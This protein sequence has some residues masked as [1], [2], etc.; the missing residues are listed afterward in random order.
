LGINADVYVGLCI[1]RGTPPPQLVA[2][3]CS[4]ATNTY[5]CGKLVLELKHHVAYS[6][7]KHVTV[8]G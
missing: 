4:G 6:N 2:L 7:A 5:V 3:Q 1:P 8:G